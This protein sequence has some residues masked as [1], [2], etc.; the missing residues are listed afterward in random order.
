MRSEAEPGPSGST[1]EATALPTDQKG[2]VGLPDIP[3]PPDKLPRSTKWYVAFQGNPALGFVARAA[4]IAVVVVCMLYVIAA[5]AMGSRWKLAF[6]ILIG[7]ARPDEAHGISYLPAALLALAGYAIV[8]AV[9]GA[10]VSVVVASV[11]FRRI[12]A[13]EAD[14]AIK[15]ALA[16]RL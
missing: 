4:L 7:G 2:Q 10:V 12:T 11:A 14:A 3:P 9:I 13:R 1:G 5:L 16:R 8:P 6:D 15:E